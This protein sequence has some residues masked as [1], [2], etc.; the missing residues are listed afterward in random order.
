MATL[1]VQTIPVYNPASTRLERDILVQ[2][3]S[4]SLVTQTE[5]V[6]TTT[7]PDPV[8]DSGGEMFLDNLSSELASQK[9]EYTTNNSFVANSLAIFYNGLNITNDVTI[10]STNTFIIDS[11]YENVIDSNGTL[12]AMYSIQ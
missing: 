9:L 12:I 1:M 4:G 8:V 5:V 7:Y 2:D 6:D 3:A 11:D 10:Q